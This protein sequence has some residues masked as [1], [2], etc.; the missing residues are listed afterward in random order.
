M[1]ARLELEPV[2]GTAGVWFGSIV[3]DQP[4]EGKNNDAG[5][6][7]ERRGKERQDCSSQT[8]RMKPR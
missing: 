5:E 1:I 3:E 6:G 7:E 8:P 2:E 4:A